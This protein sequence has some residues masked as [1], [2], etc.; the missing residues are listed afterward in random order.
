MR[1]DLELLCPRLLIA[2]NKSGNVGDFLEN[3]ADLSQVEDLTLWPREL[4]FDYKHSRIILLENTNVTPSE[5]A[6][7]N[8]LHCT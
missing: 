2:G 4:K 8:M 3:K 1:I 7:L 6:N 5:A